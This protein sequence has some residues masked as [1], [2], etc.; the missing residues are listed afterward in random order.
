MSVFA[1]LAPIAL[2]AAMFFAIAYARRTFRPRTRD[3]R[4]LATHLGMGG[5]AAWTPP[6]RAPRRGSSD[7]ATDGG[8][9]SDGDGDG[10]D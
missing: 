6:P 2:V 7:G 9:G 8:G 3:D 1:L 10:D 5:P 4:D